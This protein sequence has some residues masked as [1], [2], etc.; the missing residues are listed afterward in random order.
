MMDY[1]G[2]TGL[3][4]LKGADILSDAPKGY[5]SSVE[6]P[7]TTIGKKLKEVAQ[8]HLANLGTRI[9]YCDHG[10]FD[11]HAGQLGAHDNLLKEVN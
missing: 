6:Y 5:S 2:Q 7:D 8:V 1:L 11:N 9:L 4:T 10:G 3:D